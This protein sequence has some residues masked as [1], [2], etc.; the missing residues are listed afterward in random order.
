MATYTW[1]KYTVKET[2]TEGPPYTLSDDPYR[3]R[4]AWNSTSEQV[5]VASSYSFDTNTG[6][7]TLSGT[8]VTVTINKWTDAY[9]YKL[10]SGSIYTTSS[11]AIVIK[12]S[13][14]WI[15]DEGRYSI[16]CEQF[17]AV[18]TTTTSYSAGTYVED[19]TSTSSSAYPT[20]GQQGGYWY[21]KNEA[22]KVP[23]VPSLPSEI[24]GG[25]SIAVSWSA[26]SDTDGNLSGYQLQVS[27]DGGSWTQVYQGSSRSYSYTV[28][29]GTETIAFRV[30][31]YDSLSTYSSYA[32]STT[33]AVTNAPDAIYGYA[34][35]GGVNKML[36]GEGY[37]TIG[38]VLRP[39]VKYLICHNSVWKSMLTGTEVKTLPNGYIQLE[40]IE[41]T[42][43]QWIDTG[44]KFKSEK[45]RVVLDFYNTNTKNSVVLCGC[46]TRSPSGTNGTAACIVYSSSTLTPSTFTIETSSGATGLN[47]T[48][49]V[50]N[51]HS[52]DITA[53]NGSLEV[54]LNGE[55]YTKSYT[56]YSNKTDNFALFADNID[57]TAYLH[58]KYRL[59]ACQIYDND[60]LVR[61]FIPCMSPD[62]VIG[63]YDT[64]GGTFY[65]NNGAGEFVAG[66]P[67]AMSCYPMPKNFIQ[68]EYIQFTGSQWIDTGLKLPSSFKI[69][70]GLTPMASRGII[71]GVQWSSPKFE[72]CVWENNMGLT[73]ADTAFTSTAITPGSGYYDLICENNA[74]TI[75]GSTETRTVTAS[76]STAY[77]LLIGAHGSG[78]IADYHGQMKLYY[79]KLYSNGKLVRD[80]VP[81]KNA[82][83]VAGFWDR[84]TG[85]FYQNSGT[86]SFT[87]GPEVVNRSQITPLE[88]I[89]SSGTQYIDTCFK[90]NNNTRVV[91]DTQVT[92][93]PE[94]LNQYLFGARTSSNTVNFGMLLKG[95]SFRTDYG[96]SKVDITYSN[97]KDRITVD[98]NKDVCTLDDVVTSNAAST[99]QSSY[100]LYLFAS[101]DGGT[102]NY[103][104]SMKL[105]SCQ[106]YDNGTL[107]RDFIP[108][109]TDV[110]EVG[111]WDEVDGK[112][113]RNCGSGSFTVDVP[114]FTWAKYNAKTVQI[115]T[116]SQGAQ[117]SMSLPSTVKNSAGYSFDSSTGKFSLK[118]SYTNTGADYVAGYYKS[119]RYIYVSSSVPVAYVS[120]ATTNAI[121]YKP[122]VATA[123][124]TQVNGDFI[125]NVNSE[126]ANAYP[127][128][129]IHTDGYWY[130]KQ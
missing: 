86:G 103:F 67:V 92:T 66:E 109:I 113:Y 91:M 20:N 30:R 1:K 40:Y 72:L 129:G 87:T 68:T 102:A 84:V 94:S 6:K 112:F 114:V 15:D 17:A 27:L 41:S 48:M 21:I 105:Y 127:N 101:N 71:C 49:P 77:N 100:P 89:V 99:F 52:L 38:G 82:S 24:K 51:R 124:T 98:K 69:E 80:F 75:N 79:F 33:H 45:P 9:P 117:K 29:S 34:N 55:T 62:G 97:V 60:I 78:E 35:I 93:A 42:G 16:T 108:C 23:G 111:M 126:D 76:N 44:Y 64:S 32:T 106:I 85:K 31:A 130:V 25:N 96:E 19:V 65:P 46:E 63:L 116:E 5:K 28:P 47:L 36:T 4:Y 125:E 107:I 13:D 26:S 128:N 104:A 7:V 81:C 50:D 73:T 58:S 8:I 118:T 18:P 123:S 54:L 39:L 83:G 12:D 119:R 56:G 70:L 43:T 14:L 53:N 3:F 10:N 2:V 74:F 122:L 11:N 121:Y 37:A 90:P 88:Y 120:S 115:Y 95:A 22:P 110:G 59:Y 61:D 57:G